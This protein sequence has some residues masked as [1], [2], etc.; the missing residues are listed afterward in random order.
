VGN[1]V[2]AKPM[3]RERDV[4]DKNIIFIGKSQNENFH[5]APFVLSSEYKITT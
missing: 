3:E 4:R 5:K 1:K 2:T